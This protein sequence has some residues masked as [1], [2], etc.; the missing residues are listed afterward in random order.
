M[1]NKRYQAGARFER[2]VIHELRH[3]GYLGIRSAGSKSPY[4]VIAFRSDEPPRFI[5][6]KIVSTAAA[7]RR[8]R[9]QFLDAQ[10][11]EMFNPHMSREIWIKR[12]GEAG[13][14]MRDFVG[15][16]IKIEE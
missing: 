3:W 13:I 15:P 2:A 1:P 14:F 9:D 16:K 7:A 6:C 12:R 4:D 5:Q 10:K 8:A 11:Q